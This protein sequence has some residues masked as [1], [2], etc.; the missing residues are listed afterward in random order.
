MASTQIGGFVLA[1]DAQATPELY[2]VITGSTSDDILA[3]VEPGLLNELRSAFQS[4]N[5]F[6]TLDEG[7]TCWRKL[8]Q[9]ALH[10]LKINDRRERA[11]LV[12]TQPKLSSNKTTWETPG[13]RENQQAN[14]YG[15]NELYDYFEQFSHFESMLY[16]AE[17][18]YR[19]HLL[20]PLNVWLIGLHILSKAAT[21][22]TCRVSKHA[23][24]AAAPFARPEWE[25]PE[26]SDFEL[27]T[28]ELAAMWTIA[29]LT[30][31]LGYP[32]EKVERIND[33]LEQML[34]KFGRIEFSRSR[35]TFQTQHDHLVRQ[36]LQ[37]ISSR[38]VHCGAGADGW[39]THVRS[40][41][42]A[43]FAKSWEMFDHGIVS[44]LILMKALTYFLESDCCLD[45]SATLNLEDARQFAIRGEVL[46]AIAAHTAPKIYHLS[47]STLPFLLVLCDELQEWGRPTMAEMRVGCLTGM[48]RKVEIDTLLMPSGE[49]STI[50][51]SLHYKEADYQRQEE[52]AK[53]V[54]RAW[55]ERLRPALY[56][57]NRRMTFR[58]DLKFENSPAPWSFVL[59]TRED[60][61]RQM[62]ATKPNG[63]AFAFLEPRDVLA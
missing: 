8:L 2:S 32:L 42:L 51:C 15:F 47:A 11:Y 63:S 43:K 55:H 45:E 36:L 50:A 17:H 44:A 12:K 59:D 38:T 1:N 14:V 16:G 53:R 46:H 7:R 40:K 28:A 62:A 13:A 57:V 4:S 31:D 41:Y 3:W 54:F 60:V 49:E 48:A 18:Y 52:H 21:S 37:I 34:A 35:F 5:P 26:A 22:F 23:R 24:I 30:H 58:W 6:A 33:Q 29:A 25:N 27:S 61:F 10:F 19:D 9:S 39:R 56:D 20:H